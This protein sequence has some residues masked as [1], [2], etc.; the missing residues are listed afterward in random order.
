MRE[1]DLDRIEIPDAPMDVLAQQIV[2]MCACEDWKE[3]ELFARVRRAYP[4]RELGRSAFDSIVEMLSEGITARRGRYGAYLMRDRVNGRLH[5]RRGSRLAAIT[6]GGAIPDNALY[7]V[8][9]EPEGNAGRHCGRRLRG[10]KP[11]RRHHA[12]GE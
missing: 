3:D 6:S 7:S 10:G 11:G 4:Y 5:G 12:A 2:A 1:G 9:A 8:I